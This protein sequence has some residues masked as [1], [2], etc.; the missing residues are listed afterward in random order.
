MTVASA[1]SPP[2][3]ARAEQPDVRG[4]LRCSLPWCY[5][6]DG[7]TARQGGGFSMEREFEEGAADARDFVPE[8]DQS[9]AGVGPP[10]MRPAAPAQ[11]AARLTGPTTEQVA[12]HYAKHL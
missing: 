5:R 4:F 9:P 2:A 11:A 10:S 3:G 7:R 6:P 1:A 12:D 8:R